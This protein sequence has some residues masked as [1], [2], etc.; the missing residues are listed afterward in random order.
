[1]PRAEPVSGDV[2]GILEAQRAHHLEQAEKIDKA[3][4][5]LR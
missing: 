5:V 2:V 1:M 4:A 3:L